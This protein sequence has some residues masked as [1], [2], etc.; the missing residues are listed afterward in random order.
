MDKAHCV[1]QSDSGDYRYP[2]AE[3]MTNG[4]IKNLTFVMTNDQQNATAT[5]GGYCLH[6]DCRTKNDVGY[7]M[8]IEDCDMVDASG[9]CLGIGI[10][11]NCTLTI[12]RCN[13]HTTLA[14]NYAPHQGYTN[15]KDY[16]VI[17]CHTSTRS[18]ATNQKIN[19]ED[20]V[21]LCDNGN[22][23]LQIAA[24]GDYDPSTASFYYRLIRNVFWNATQAAP[25]YS[26]SGSLTA[27]PMNYGNNIPA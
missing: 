9:P 18:D 17:F 22:K 5:K 19:I 4:I 2:C 13:L 7:D 8:R 25:S 10:H 21:G 6:V 11:K 1:I 27:D 3:L 23:G 26:I 20:C 16:G 15:L 24:A 12:R 14:A